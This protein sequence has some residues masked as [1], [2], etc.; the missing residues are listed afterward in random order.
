MIWEYFGTTVGLRAT[1]GTEESII[2]YKGKWLQASVLGFLPVQHPLS[3]E[4]QLWNSHCHDAWPEFWQERKREAQASILGFLP[5]ELPSNFENFLGRPFLVAP[6]VGGQTNAFSPKK[7]IVTGTS[8]LFFA[9]AT[10]T[11]FGK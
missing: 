10:S 5:M 3:W 4:V 7:R 2:R 9:S 11:F 8:T 6:N 1:L